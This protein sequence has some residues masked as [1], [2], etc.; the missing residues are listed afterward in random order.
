MIVAVV[1]LFFIVP[2]LFVSHASHPLYICT[3]DHLNL[4]PYK[5]RPDLLRPSAPYQ[6]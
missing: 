2:L 1:F 6:Q 3:P 5:P 4:A